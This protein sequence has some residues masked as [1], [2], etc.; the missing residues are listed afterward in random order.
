MNYLPRQQLYQLIATYG[1]SLCDDPRRCEALLKDSYG[2][3]R[4]EIAVLVGALREGVAADLLASQNS[5]PQTVLLARL[6]KRLHDNL[7]LTE[8]AAKWGVESWAL[9]LGMICAPDD[10]YQLQMSVPNLNASFEHQPPSVQPQYRQE[11]PAQYSSSAVPNPSWNV[12]PQASGFVQSDSFQAE[13]K[14]REYAGFWKRFLA[15]ILDGVILYIFGSVIGFIIG[16]AYGS[17]SG[18]AEGSRVV[19]FFLGLILGWLYFALM[20]SSRQRATL[21][22]QALGIIVTDLN[23]NRISFGRATAR[24]F[25]KFI[26]GAILC[27][28]FIM[29]G[30]TEKKQALHDMIA[31]CL[32]VKK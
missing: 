30:F 21:G 19:G 29:A 24:H 3:Y 1:R 2:Q 9:A 6:T 26:S 22:K 12:Q 8:D 7:A 15:Y 16:I 5:V 20:E 13:V 31:G 25:S 18:T 11:I 17:A 28:G 27:I 23:G 14:T 32:V 10:S 4:P